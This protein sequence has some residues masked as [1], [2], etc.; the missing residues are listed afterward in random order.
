MSITK[1]YLS[2]KK[3]CK[4]TFALPSGL[5]ETAS[6]AN[7][8]GEFNNWDT[9]GLPMKKK[10]GS[11]TLTIELQLNKKYQFRYLVDGKNWETDWD[12]DEI[13]PI[14]FSDEL[15]SVVNV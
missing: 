4:V 13:A 5:A 14:P 1:K 2:T 10:N 9:E 15:N 12:V 8:V 3:V 7:L 6:K 11:F